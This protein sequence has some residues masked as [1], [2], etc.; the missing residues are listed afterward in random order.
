LRDY[1]YI[2]LGA[3]GSV[4]ATLTLSSRTDDEA[5]ELG[6]ELLAKS[7]CSELEVMKGKAV[8]FR[9]AREVSNERRTA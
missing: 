6:S 3:D 4:E 7:E 9:I 5:C 8:L 2:F 1:R